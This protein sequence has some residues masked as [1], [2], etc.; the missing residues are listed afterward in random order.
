[1]GNLFQDTRSRE[2]A[3]IR[4]QFWWKLARLIPQGIQM[5]SHLR[6]CE[7]FWNSDVVKDTYVLI[8]IHNMLKLSYSFFGAKDWLAQTRLATGF[9]TVNKGYQ[10]MTQ[11]ANFVLGIMNFPWKFLQNIPL[12]QHVV[13]FLWKLCE[14]ALLVKLSIQE[15]RILSYASCPLCKNEIESIN[16]LF[17]SCPFARGFWFGSNLSIRS[18]TFCPKHIIQ[19]KA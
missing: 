3:L 4:S 9:Y 12:P 17:L 1:M 15:R 10:L 18:D 14:K 8:V 7:G 19:E 16:H 5:I 11:S 13:V 2:N 6:S